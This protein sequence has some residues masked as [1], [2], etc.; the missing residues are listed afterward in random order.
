[1]VHW[2]RVTIA[3]VMLLHSWVS[4]STFPSVVLV[5]SHK[6]SVSVLS[7]QLQHELYLLTILLSALLAYFLCFLIL[8]LLY[9][10]GGL[11]LALKEDNSCEVLCECPYCYSYLDLTEMHY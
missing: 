1:M 6:A 4:V 8:S 7:L 10:G 5:F 11:E 3:P 2:H 9:F